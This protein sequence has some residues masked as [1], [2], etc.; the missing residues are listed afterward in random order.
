MVDPHEVIHPKDRLQLIAVLF[1]GG[2]DSYSVAL[3]RWKDEKE[4]QGGVWPYAL[5]IRWNG[6]PDP[7]DKGVPSS[8]GYPTW[9]ILPRD[10]V[11]WI[12]EGLL[13]RP[14]SNMAAL[15]LA[16]EK[17]LGGEKQPQG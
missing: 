7:R 13:Q 6:G 12:L 11:P 1:D 4:T 15:T 2:A 5:G 8:R 16:R 14:E 17:L 9:Y 10:L 3:V